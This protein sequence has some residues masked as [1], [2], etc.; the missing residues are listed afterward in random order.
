MVIMG[1]LLELGEGLREAVP[2]PPQ[3][4]TPNPV[5]EVGR[6]SPERLIR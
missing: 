3:A 6:R 1:W 5:Q 2:Y 4:P